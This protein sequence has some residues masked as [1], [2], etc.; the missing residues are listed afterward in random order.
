MRS[1][2][3]YRRGLSEI[4]LGDFAAAAVDL[5]QVTAQDPK[6][7]YQRAAGLLAHALG[8]ARPS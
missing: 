8:E 7:D 6:Y 3:R 1:I 5:Q 4:E 2:P